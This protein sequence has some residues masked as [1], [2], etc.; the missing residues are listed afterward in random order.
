[1]KLRQPTR[2][3]G[4][5]PSR[6]RIRRFPYGLKPVPNKAQRARI[7][8][9]FWTLWEKVRKLRVTSYASCASFASLLR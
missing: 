6:S 8:K 3:Q 5:Y 4:C 7:E 1:M 2:G 9:L